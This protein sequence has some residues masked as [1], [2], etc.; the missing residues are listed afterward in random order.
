HHPGGTRCPYREPPWDFGPGV[1]AILKLVSLDQTI[2]YRCPACENPIPH[3]MSVLPPAWRIGASLP[4]ASW[5]TLFA[6]PACHTVY[7]A[8]HGLPC[9]MVE[10]D[11]RT[12]EPFLR[13]YETVRDGEGSPL[14]LEIVRGLPEL[15]PNS[16]PRE[17]TTLWRRRRQAYERL[18]T[19]MRWRASTGGASLK[20]LDLG[21]GNGWLSWRLHGLGHQ[22]VA[23]D[24]CL[25]PHHGLGMARRVAGTQGMVGDEPRFIC[26]Q[27]SMERLPFVDQQFDL[28][29]AAASLHYARSITRAVR[30][31]A[32]VLIPGGA[33]ILIYTPI[34]ETTRAGVTVV[35]RRLAE[36]RT[37]FGS[38]GGGTAGQGFL[39]RADLRRT[40]HLAGL[41]YQEIAVH[42]ALRATAGGFRR[43]V[44]RARHRRESAI[45]PLVLGEK[46]GGPC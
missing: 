46:E 15:P 21:A 31:A 34:Y 37:R 23:T 36:Q 6:C 13:H 22:V 29:I 33:L 14:P 40:F 28:V 4:S 43:W 11:L 32:R 27:A 10:G 26:V 8:V 35:A 39:V 44:R 16:Y 42:G 19:S 12:A 5:E 7:S 20:V 1:L 3:A 2:Q 38:E 17:M 24:I 25:S 45:M 30:E 9:L 18:I 41:R